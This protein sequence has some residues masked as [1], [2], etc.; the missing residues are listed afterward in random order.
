MN[1]YFTNNENLK[2]EIRYLDYKYKDISLTLAS[3]N[4]VFAKDKIDY[5]S[6]LL[7]E[8][9]VQKSNIKMGD[10]LDLGCGYG[11]IGLALKKILD[12]NITLSDI[13]KRAVHLTK[14][15]VKNNKLDAKVLL[16]DGFKEIK[17]T[18]DV[19]ISNPP[20]RVG[21]KILLDLLTESLKHLK[22]NGE[23]WCVIRKDQGA[24]SIINSIANISNSEIIEK[25]KGF[26]I[27]KFISN[28]Y[29]N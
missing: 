19:I 23:L 8:T 12:I 1:H 27:I 2:S 13:N 15:N 28:N 7:A 3:D 6:K 18:F 22:E 17:E 20:I 21:K 4:G 24:K 16:S 26:L 14:M 25:S 11:F 9:F 29:D 5:G 10:F